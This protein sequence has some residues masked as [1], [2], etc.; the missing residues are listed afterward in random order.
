MFIAAVFTVVSLGLMVLC[1]NIVGPKVL[2]MV[3]TFVLSFALMHIV[4]LFV[5]YLLSL[6]C[7]RSR[8][9]EKQNR[10]SRACCAGVAGM[11]SAYERMTLIPRG[12]AKVPQD[13]RFLFVCNHRSMFDPL[14]VMDKLAA[15]NISFVSKPSNLKIPM[16]GTI[17]HQAGFLAIDRDNDRKALQTI[18]TAA[19]YIK[20]DVCSIGIYPEGHRSKDGQLLPFHAGSFKIA[21]KAKCPLV[22][23]CIRGTEGRKGFL[24]RDNHVVVL[25]ILDVLEPEQVTAMSTQ[26]LSDYSRSLMEAALAQPLAEDP[27]PALEELLLRSREDEA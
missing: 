17:A 25:D 21:Q 15:L 27:A 22:I 18:L 26:E 1:L 4:Y 24:F 3:L 19:D 2:P 12:L 5:Y 16:V 6:P 7:D 8:P 9:I 10:H 13:R 14:V 23:A 11:L 20:R